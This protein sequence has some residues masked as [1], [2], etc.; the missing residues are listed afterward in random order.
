MK[1]ISLLA[2]LLLILLQLG[3]CSSSQKKFENDA[4]QVSIAG[5]SDGTCDVSVDGWKFIVRQKSDGR[6]SVRDS[7]ISLRCRKIVNDS[8]H[9]GDT[10]V[11][12]S[13]KYDVNEKLVFTEIDEYLTTYA[14]LRGSAI[15]GRFTPITHA[16]PLFQNLLIDL[17][18]YKILYDPDAEPSITL[19]GLGRRTDRPLLFY[20]RLNEK[21]GDSGIQAFSVRQV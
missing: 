20:Q 14:T 2:T 5:Y 1:T 18:E 6:Y 16:T 10:W 8:D 12:I 9:S 4:Y 7:T 21:F 13:G 15:S 19:S 17:Y 11:Y 3:A